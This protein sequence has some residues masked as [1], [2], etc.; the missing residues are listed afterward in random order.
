MVSWFQKRN[1]TIKFLKD[2]S[3][4]SPDIMLILGSSLGEIANICQKEKEI[5]FEEIPYMHSPAAKTHQGKLIIGQIH[6]KRVVIQQGR[7]HE[8][9]GYD[10][11]ETTFLVNCFGKIGCRKLITTDLAGGITGKEEDIVLIKDHIYL[12]G[13]NPLINIEKKFESKQFLD[14][15]QAYSEKLIS[16]AKEVAV[17]KRLKGL[18]EGVFAYL[19]GPSFETKSELRILKSWGADVVSWSMIPEVI[20]GVYHGMEVL[21]MSCISD[22]SDPD[23]LKEVDLN[24][25]YNHGN[26]VAKKAGKLINGVINE[27]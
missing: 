8:Y 18:R 22:L 19:T 11:R 27:L 3:G 4:E 25:L 17:K 5:S 6:N 20:V 21:A 2:W 10:L 26:N 15:T 9:E 13:H 12:G 23:N 24:I 16:L 7:L 14:L 1:R